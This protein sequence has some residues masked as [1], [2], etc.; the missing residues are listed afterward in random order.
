M[1]KNGKYR[2]TA[3]R[4][5]QPYSQLVQLKIREQFPRTDDSEISTHFYEIQP[6]MIA[7][8]T[9][10]DSTEISVHSLNERF[11]SHGSKSFGGKICVFYC[12]NASPG[13]NNII[14]GL[15]KFQQQK[16]G[17][18]ILGILTGADGIEKE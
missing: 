16:K 4:K 5:Y 15:L 18:E 13:G 6:K 9:F 14:D 12:G 17:L 3:I 8:N 1:L 2:I 7:D 11:K 10:N